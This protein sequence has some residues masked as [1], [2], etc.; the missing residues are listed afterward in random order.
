MGF[1]FLHKGITETF[2]SS[3]A[4]N[5][6]IIENNS[7]LLSDFLWHSLLGANL[8]VH[9]SLIDDHIRKAIEIKHSGHNHNGIA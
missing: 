2:I 5:L 6:E 1:S 3:I 4:K 8:P 9:L 7:L